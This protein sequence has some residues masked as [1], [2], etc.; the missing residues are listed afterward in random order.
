[1]LEWCES[2]ETRAAVEEAL[3]KR[4]KARRLMKS[5]RTP[6]TWKALRAACKGVRAVVDEGIHAHLERYVTSLEALYE[7]R[8]LRGLYKHLKES[9][10]LGGRQSGGRQYNKDENGVLLRD[11]AEI[12]QRWAR[13]FSTLL[14]TKSP[15]L[16]PAI[17]EEVQQR[18]AAPRRFGT[19]WIGSNAGGDKTSNPGDAQLESAWA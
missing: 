16:D 3:A 2:P 19:A 7:Y 13:F 5:N 10:G 1:M 15:K 8:D 14:N 11:N 18:P 4:R 9:V 17:I 6:A 12:L